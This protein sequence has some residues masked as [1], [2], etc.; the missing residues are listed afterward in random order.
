MNGRTIHSNQTYG[1]PCTQ[2]EEINRK[3]MAMHWETN[4]RMWQE[5]SMLVH[6]EGCEAS[7]KRLQISRRHWVAKHTEG[8]CGV[9]KWLVILQERETEDCPTCSEFEHAQHV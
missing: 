4:D 7:M 9:G 8:M 5:R 6:W 1:T 2:Y 3:K